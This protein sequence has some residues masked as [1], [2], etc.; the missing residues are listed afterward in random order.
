MATALYVG[1]RTMAAQPDGDNASNIWELMKQ[2]V[3]QADHA[4]ITGE[5]LQ[6]LQNDPSV[7]GAE[8]RII[9]D[10]KK[11]PSYGKQAY[12][13]PGD[14]TDSEDPSFT[15]NGPSKNF[16]VGLATSN[17]AFL[18]VHSGTLY[19]TNTKVSKDGTISTTWKVDDNF[20]YIPDWENKNH[21]SF[22]HK[23]T[24]NIGAW[25]SQ[26]IYNGLLGAKKQV[27]TNAYWQQ[28][29]L[30]QNVLHSQ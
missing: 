24:Y 10:I 25:I 6:S 23:W 21:R 18:M 29:I 27:R 11:D 3:E 5:G 1:V 7:Q 30:P 14:Y 12:L 28:T 4:N 19:A 26:P 8:N 13:I 20:D 9:A 17:P 15:A 16:L 22:F 2:G